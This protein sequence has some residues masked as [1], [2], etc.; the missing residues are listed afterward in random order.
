MI[1]RKHSLLSLPLLLTSSLLGFS[2][3]AIAKPLAKSPGFSGTIGI[4]AGFSDSQNQFNTD[5]DNAQTDDL[6]NPGKDIST[7]LLF[8]FFRVAYTSEDLQTQYFL[9][10]SPQNIL[11]SA[12]QYELGVTHKFDERQSMMLAYIPHVPFLK[13]TWS[14]PFLTDAARE[15]SD[16]DSTA[17]RVAYKFAPVQVE[18]AYASYDIEDEQSGAQNGACNGQNCTAEEQALLKR[19]SDYQRLSLESS[20][21]LWQGMFAKANVYYA[22]Q[23]SK[24]ESQSYDELHYSLSIMTKYERHFLSVQAAFSDREYSAENPMFG[25]TQQQDAA[26]YSLIYAYTEPFN[27]ADTN[28]NVIYQNKDIDANI[29]FYDSTTNFVSV[30]MSY[31]F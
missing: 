7:G 19:D 15:K 27:I 31:N 4:N 21:R 18:Y 22:N 26:R 3:V 2:S 29:D 17:V 1:S 13:E 23:D 6:N 14:D 30:G 12:I 5:N 28:L 16:I 11:D 20:L 25:Q 10:Q 24:G 8:P 9:G